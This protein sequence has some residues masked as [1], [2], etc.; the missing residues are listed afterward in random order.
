MLFSFT[1]E[2]SLKVLLQQTFTLSSETVSFNNLYDKNEVIM[3]SD[4]CS[5]TCLLM[6]KAIIILSICTKANL[7][8]ICWNRCFR[9][10]RTYECG[11]E[12][13]YG[14]LK[15]SIEKFHVTL[16]RW[17]CLFSWLLMKKPVSN[18]LG[19]FIKNIIL[20]LISSSIFFY[21]NIR[22]PLFYYKCYWHY[23]HFQCEI[24]LQKQEK[25]VFLLP[26]EVFKAS[27]LLTWNSLFIQSDERFKAVTFSSEHYH[28]VNR[29]MPILKTLI[30][31]YRYDYV[32]RAEGKYYNYYFFFIREMYLKR[33]N[34]V[35][36]CSHCIISTIL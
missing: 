6:M 24:V 29:M 17:Y 31:N 5:N 11:N 18:E 4:L 19:F 2:S 12:D 20:I 22:F 25:L 13:A 1:V 27:T 26:C 34:F 32:N 35:K 7:I 36:S 30:S 28:T 15:S 16:T 21:V 23:I 3:L 14:N 10:Y 33:N 8:I 9:M